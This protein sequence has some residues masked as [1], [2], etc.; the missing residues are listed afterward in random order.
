ML[1]LLLSHLTF[2]SVALFGKTVADKV[3]CSFT[4]IVALCLSRVIELT[5]VTLETL[6]IQVALTPFVAVA[7]IVAVP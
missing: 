3:I 5:G 4:I 6:T 2:L 1:W 7:V